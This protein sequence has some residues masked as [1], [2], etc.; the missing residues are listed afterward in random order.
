METEM[1][2]QEIIQMLT[3]RTKDFSQKEFEEINRYVSTL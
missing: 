2:A 1:I 3:E